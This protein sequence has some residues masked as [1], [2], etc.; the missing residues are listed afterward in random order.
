[1]SF[2][3]YNIRWRYEIARRDDECDANY[4]DAKFPPKIAFCVTLANSFACGVFLAVCF[5]SLLPS[6]NA[7]LL[8]ALL[9]VKVV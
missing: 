2:Q 7:R 6:S 5:L 8:L 3:N 1:M 4:S 9:I